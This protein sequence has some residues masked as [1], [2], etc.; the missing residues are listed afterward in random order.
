M[1]NS[2]SDAPVCTC[3]STEITEGAW[4][5]RYRLADCPEHGQLANPSAW[6]NAPDQRVHQQSDPWTDAGGHV[7]ELRPNT[8]CDECPHCL[9]TFAAIHT[10]EPEGYDC[11]NCDGCPDTHSPVVDD[12]PETDAMCEDC[13][14]M[15][16]IGQASTRPSEWGYETYVVQGTCTMCGG[17]GRRST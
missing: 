16:Q 14:G 4:T 12:E 15:G 8:A 10:V 6:T 17:T 13:H 7:W 3:P 5:A 11:P 1:S 9:F 2:T